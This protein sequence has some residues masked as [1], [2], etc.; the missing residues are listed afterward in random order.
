[1]FTQQH[2]RAFK[3]N[4]HGQ[5][6]KRESIL[7]VSVVSEIHIIYWSESSSKVLILI[8]III[9]L[10]MI[11]N[12]RNHLKVKEKKTF[13]PHTEEELR[14]CSWKYKMHEEN[15]QLFQ[16]HFLFW[17]F[18]TRMPPDSHYG[19]YFCTG[20]NNECFYVLSTTSMFIHCFHI[21]CYLAD[22]Q[23]ISSPGTNILSCPI[24]NVFFLFEVKYYH[25]RSF[26][27]FRG[28]KLCMCSDSSSLT[29]VTSW[30]AL[31]ATLRIYSNITSPLL[32]FWLITNRKTF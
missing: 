13:V 16:F 31:C 27:P 25:S 21:S 30:N 2:C 23:A 19:P 26:L 11:L 28:C 29:I 20:R 18:W 12:D 17:L 32:D 7:H 24:V 10:G 5:F 6:L 22:I 8:F 4:L 9:S 14:I 1:M 3:L 15:I